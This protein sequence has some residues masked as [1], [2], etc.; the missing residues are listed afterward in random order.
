MAKIL[1]A[2]PNTLVESLQGEKIVTFIT[3]DKE[4]KEPQISAVSWVLAQPDGKTIKIAVG[5]NAHC[6]SNVQ[7]NPQVTLGVIGA[8]SYF[9]IKGTAEVSDIHNGTMKF[10]V[11]T[12]S[13]QTVEDVMF[14]GG[15]VTVE[16]QYEKTYDAELAKKLD[17]EIYDVLRQ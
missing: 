8:E 14:Y 6:A 13:V 4:T 17:Q 16:P 11:I 7:A 12:V 3:L 9:E 1:D 5:H 15:K 2:L 10:R